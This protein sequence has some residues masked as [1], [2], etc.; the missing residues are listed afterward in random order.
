MKKI[1]LFTLF[2]VG[3]QF[4]HAAKND[5]V[6]YYMKKT[7]SSRINAIKTDQANCGDDNC[8]DC[9][10]DNVPSNILTTVQYISLQVKADTYAQQ[11]SCGGCGND[12]CGDDSI[13]LPISK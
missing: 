12:N 9:N 8:G 11:N 6:P 1:A 4:A 7:D 13:D 10:G 3:A 2:L 5:S